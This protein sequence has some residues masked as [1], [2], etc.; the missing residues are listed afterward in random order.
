MERLKFNDGEWSQVVSYVGLR[1]DR[2]ASE[3]RLFMS[4]TEIV[5]Y[6]V[7]SSLNQLNLCEPNL[8]N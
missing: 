4:N 2:I 3:L 1:F 6:K 5:S 7:E 8:L